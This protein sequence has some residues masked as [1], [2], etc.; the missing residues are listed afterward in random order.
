MSELS[1]VIRTRNC[2]AVL[3][4]CLDC[5][6][7]QTYRDAEWIVVD[8]RSADGSAETAR[9]A[10]ARVISVLPAAFTYGGALN[11]GFAEAK[12]RFLCSL[13]AHALFMEPTVLERL[14]AALRDADD[15]VAGAYGCPVFTDEQALAPPAGLPAERIQLADF[16]RLCNL[17]LSNSCSVIRRERWESFPFPPERCEDQKWA[18]HFLERGGATLRVPSARYR[19]R[20]NRSCAYYARKHRDDLLMLHR[21]WPACPWP[22]E[23]LRDAARNRYRLWCAIGRLKKARWEWDRISDYRKWLIGEEL[24]LFWAGARTRG[25]RA[26][27]LPLLADLAR[28]LILPSGLKGW[29]IP[30]EECP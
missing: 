7:R 18:A 9:A 4:E 15:P 20:L 1:I 10:G 5:L 23:A 28:V 24:G 16:S 22:R 11:L 3:R 17:G 30:P 13:S 12:G 26:W 19:Y 29:V 2:R 25:G 6:A 21:T 27:L 8:S 14:V